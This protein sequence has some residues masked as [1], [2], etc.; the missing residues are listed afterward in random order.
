LVTGVVVDMALVASRKPDDLPRFHA[1]IIE[2]IRED[3][4]TG[5]IAAP[6]NPE[7]RQGAK[8]GGCARTPD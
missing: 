2:E 3:G 8:A 5:R 4:T 1:K 7:Q 6:R